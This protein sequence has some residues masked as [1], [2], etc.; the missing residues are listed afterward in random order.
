M[1]YRFLR[2]LVDFTGDAAVAVLLSLACLAG[3]VA[4]VGEPEQP[5]VM[6]VDGGRE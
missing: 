1:I 4:E 3:V 6:H 5:M 2:W